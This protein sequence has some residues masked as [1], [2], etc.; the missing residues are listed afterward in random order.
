MLITQAQRFDAIVVT[1]DPAFGDYD[2]KVLP[3]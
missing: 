2:V 1:R 3:A